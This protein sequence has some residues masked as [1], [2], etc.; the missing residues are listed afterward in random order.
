MKTLELRPEGPEYELPAPDGSVTL[1]EPHWR[2]LLKQL[3]DAPPLDAKGQQMG[4]VPDLMRK[5]IRLSKIAAKLTDDD[6]KVELEDSDAQEFV[7]ALAGV[8]WNRVSEWLMDF[9]DAVN[10]LPKQKENGKAE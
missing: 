6:M 8:R 7:N 3:V 10:A 1:K 2:M 5:R 4:F 9:T